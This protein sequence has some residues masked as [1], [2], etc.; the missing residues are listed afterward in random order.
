MSK[1]SNL[2]AAIASVI[3]TNG[4]QAI[5]GSVLQSVL[6]NIVS[7]LGE[8]YQFVGIATTATNP[9]TPDGNVFYIAGEGTYVNFSNLVIDIGQL[10]ILKW[11]GTWSKQVLEIG[12]GGGNMILDWNTDV[13]TTRK[14]V[15]SKLRKPGMQISY[16][17]PDNGW[18]N[19]QYTGA[20]VNDAERSNDNK[21]ETIPNQEELLRIEG[22][23]G[24]SFCK[25][26]FYKEKGNTIVNSSGS[27]SSYAY[28][29]TTDYIEVGEMKSVSIHNL[30]TEIG[31]AVAVAF[32]DSEKSFISAIP[33]T[34]T[35]KLL[36]PVLAVF[37]SNCKYFAV[38]KQSASNSDA[39]KIYTHITANDIGTIRTKADIGTV[40]GAQKVE[41]DGSSSKFIFNNTFKEGDIIHIINAK[42]QSNTYWWIKGYIDG[43]WETVSSR[44]FAGIMITRDI[45]IPSGIEKYEKLSIETESPLILSGYAYFITELTLQDI[46][47]IK[48]IATYTDQLKELPIIQQDVLLSS[49]NLINPVIVQLLSNGFWVSD[50]IQVNEGETYYSNTPLGFFTYNESKANVTS[51]KPFASG[52]PI[53][54][55]VSFVR[56]KIGVSGNTHDEESAIKKANDLWLSKNNEASKFAKTFNTYLI[57][58]VDSGARDMLGKLMPHAGKGLFCVGDS[59]T[60]QR[61]YFPALLAVTGLNKIGDTGGDGNGQPL[62]LFAKNIIKYKEQ[63]LQCKFVTIL[64]GTNDYGHGGEKL[65]TINDCIKDEYAELK[66]PILK[67]N[68]EGYYIKDDSVD[69][70]YKVLTEE[71]INAGQ[72]PKSVYAAIMTCVNIIHGWDKTITVVL[73]SQPERLPYSSQ[74]CDPPLLRNG[75][76]MD[77][78]AKAMREIH[79]MFGVPYYDFHSNG[80]TIDQV[81]VYM[82]DGTLHPNALGGEKIGRGLGMYINSL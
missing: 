38:S 13:A 10:G 50:Y 29:K 46:D 15:I 5:T 7:S 47:K 40:F 67:L 26:V 11:N 76:N 42:A 20:A 33:Y 63:I 45:S 60:M 8:N 31:G 58:V 2:K 75:M 71:E 1:W 24:V 27:F 53:P 77:L 78:L 14:Q 30:I 3:K 56:A 69:T 52:S 9:G 54:S 32:Y 74:S 66:V 4:T 68:E 64:G 65:G 19:E 61:A 28:G 12:A 39:I 35:K 79:E 73:C 43:T 37:P 51:T 72:T 36:P 82:N 48:D 21:W 17:D 81:E 6:N 44:M 55:G 16:K 23:I 70:T 41:A 57:N 25:E 80:W 49:D 59:Y 22:N 18:I 62:T 34:T